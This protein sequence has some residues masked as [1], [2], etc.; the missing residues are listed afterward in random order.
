MNFT[1]LVHVALPQVASIAVF[2]LACRAY[3]RHRSFGFLLLVF[4]F[5]LGALAAAS[6]LLAFCGGPALLAA[7]EPEVPG[8]RLVMTF[9]PVLVFLFGFLLLGNGGAAPKNK[10]TSAKK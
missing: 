7:L 4:G 3:L 1:A 9:G 2:I 6:S 8:L 5:G 10:S